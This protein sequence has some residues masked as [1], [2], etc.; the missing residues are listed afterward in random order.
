[1]SFTKATQDFFYICAG[2][3]SDRGFCLPDADEAAAVAARKKK[4]ELDREIEQVK[5]EYD[6]KQKLKREKRK[7][8]Q[9]EKG[10]DKDKEKDDET[11][12]SE[13]EQDKDDEKTKDDK[14]GFML[15]CYISMHARIQDSP[16]DSYGRSKSCH[17]PKTKLKSIW[18]PASSLS[19]S[20]YRKYYFAT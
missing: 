1:M 17:N 4:E 5:K 13:E 16:A 14:V 6:E 2:H 7:E 12:K 10:K 18:D 20:T 3:L 15:S 19:K 9:K 11:K 8:K